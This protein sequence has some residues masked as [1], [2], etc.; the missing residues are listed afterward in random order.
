[1]RVLNV[2]TKDEIKTIKDA[3]LTCEWQ[4]GK[5]SAIGA[6]KDIK[7][8]RQIFAQQKGFAPIST[9]VVDKLVKGNARQIL[10]P[11]SIVGL[12]ANSYSVGETYGWHVDMAH[13]SLKRTDMSFTIFLSE[14]DSYEGG[15]LDIKSD[16]FTM[17]V[18]GHP[19]EMVIYDT[20]LLHQVRPVTKGERVCIIGWIE[21]LV[22][23]QSARQILMDYGTNL[24]AIKRRLDTSTPPEQ[25]EFDNLNQNFFQLIRKLTP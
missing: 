16:G 10:F 2:F 21:S 13:M 6:A 24:A 15:E 22:P 11:K 12:R 25:G 7:N 17:T 23:D 5:D 8:N 4:N 18:K 19:G 14:K 20:G 3:L 9:L 1:M